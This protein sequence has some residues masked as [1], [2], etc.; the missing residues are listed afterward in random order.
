MSFHFIPSELLLIICDFLYPRDLI[1]FRYLSREYEHIVTY[2][3]DSRYNTTKLY[4]LICPLC[5]NDWI[6]TF[7]IQDDYMDIDMYLHEAEVLD[8]N[9]FIKNFFPTKQ[10]IR[11]RLLCDD[12]ENFKE[13]FPSVDTFK[14][15]G[16]PYLYQL[17]HIGN[18]NYPWVFLTKQKDGIVLWNE[19]N[20]N[21]QESDD[22]YHMEYLYESYDSD[23]F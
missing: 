15:Y 10:T 5:A 6:S 11:S 12:C 8:R 2:Y 21:N 22:E 16:S 7:E 20:T 13:S 14:L 18:I 19:I 9:Q 3:L 1:R 23:E 17:Y 4:D